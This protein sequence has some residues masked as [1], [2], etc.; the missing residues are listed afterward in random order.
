MIYSNASSMA[1]KRH[2]QGCVIDLYSFAH[3]GESE[4]IRLNCDAAWQYYTRLNVLCVSAEA[5]EANRM[6]PLKTVQ[7]EH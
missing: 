2:Y 4:S 7:R 3:C 6:R 5:E 1:F